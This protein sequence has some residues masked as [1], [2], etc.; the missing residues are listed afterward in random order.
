MGRL[1]PGLI[2]QAM[3]D[4]AP[5]VRENVIKLAEMQMGKAPELEEALLAMQSDSDPKVRF[6]LLCTLGFLEGTQA[7]QA[8]KNLLFSDIEDEWIQIAALSAPFEESRKLLDAVLKDYNDNIGWRRSVSLMAQKDENLRVRAGLLFNREEGKGEELIQ[9]YQPALEVEGSKEVGRTVF[10]N[11][12]AVCHKMGDETGS[13]YGPDLAS[14]KNRRPACIMA[15]ILDPNLSIADGYDLW[16]VEMLNGEILQG[17]ISSETPTTI[18]L[19]NAGG[20]ERNISRRDIKT[21]RV[22]DMSA[23]PVGLESNINHQEMVD[24][25]AWW[26]GTWKPLRWVNMMFFWNGRCLMKRQESLMSLKPRNNS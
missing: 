21:F 17:I 25:L 14:L 11:N 18:S 13:A 3:D 4:S 20:Q 24:L 1:E 26:N 16:S 8:R 5:G 15:D 6:Q 22:M 23:M 10:Q 2:I 19:R 12:C 7:A 9:E